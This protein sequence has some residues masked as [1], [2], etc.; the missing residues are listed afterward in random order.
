MKEPADVQ[1][2]RRL[3]A[4]RQDSPYARN[5][6]AAAR[7]AGISPSRLHMIEG[8]EVPC[9]EA[10]ANRILGLYRPQDQPAALR[11]LAFARGILPLE[12]LADWRAELNNAGCHCWVCRRLVE[13][14]IT[15]SAAGPGLWLHEIAHALRAQPTEGPLGNDKHDGRFADIFS[16]LVNDYCCIAT[17]A[18]TP[19][20]RRVT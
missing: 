3:E 20:D 8:A 1:L 4:A 17:N 16:R 13:A 5:L 10:L 15:A 18:G 2:A 14:T 9:P 19:A 12:G 7:A 11:W 6:S